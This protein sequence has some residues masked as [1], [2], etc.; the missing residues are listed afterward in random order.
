MASAMNEGK[1]YFDRH[2]KYPC[3]IIYE[4]AKKIS[5]DKAAA[6]YKVVEK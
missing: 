5:K 2:R 4:Y 1:L 6:I 3:R